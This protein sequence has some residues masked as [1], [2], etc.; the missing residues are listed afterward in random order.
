MRKISRRS[1]YK[2]TTWNAKRRGIPW[3]LNYV[4][5]KTIWAESGKWS[6]RGNKSGYYVMARFKDQGPYASWN[7]R[8]IPFGENIREAHLG[9]KRSPESCERISRSKIGNQ[10]GRG[11]KG[12]IR[13]PE[14]R[15]Q[16]SESLK[17]W[18][19]KPCS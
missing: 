10:Y 13:S 7:V 2:N 19:Q 3:L 18:Y 6:L 16:I 9:K 15:K 17:E 1:V 14:C 8:I 11:N 5:W 12:K 4:T